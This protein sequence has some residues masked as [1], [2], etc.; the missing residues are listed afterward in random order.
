MKS[1]I[2]RIIRKILHHLLTQVLYMRKVIIEA[3]MYQAV[4]YELVASARAVKLV[5][6][7][8]RFSNR[9]YDCDVSNLSSYLQS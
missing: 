7:L 2:K 8:I 1:I 4:H 6:R 5:M 3:I 9:L